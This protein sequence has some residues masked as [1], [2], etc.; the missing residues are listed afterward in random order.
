MR[1]ASKG[2]VPEGRSTTT[3]RSNAADEGDTQQRQRAPGEALVIP[4]RNARPI[5]ASDARQRN[6]K[7]SAA[8]AKASA[9]DARSAETTG[10]D[11]Q[12]RRAPAGP[13]LVNLDMPRSEHRRSTEDDKALAEG[14]V[15][16]A[17]RAPSR[18]DADP[19]S[20]QRS[21]RDAS[22]PDIETMQPSQ[23]AWSPAHHASMRP[24]R[25]AIRA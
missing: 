15:V 14:T 20:G 18:P 17:P 24:E 1:Y 4:A 6:R 16:A 11:A 21:A 7:A 2:A 23:A 3:G 10:L 12:A 9:I 25:V 22:G 13:G 19:M 8:G 5:K